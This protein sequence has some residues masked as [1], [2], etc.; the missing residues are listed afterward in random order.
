MMEIST[1]GPLDLHELANAHGA[2]KAAKE[3]IKRGLWDEDAG[4]PLKTYDVTLE[5]S[6]KVLARPEDE[7]M[8][9]A[10]REIDVDSDAICA[11]EVP[12]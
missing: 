8:D 6:K 4:K 11:V 3:L 1:L 10:E 7:A 12:G 2:G 5:I 9:K